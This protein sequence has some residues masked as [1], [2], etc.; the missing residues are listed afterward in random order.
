MSLRS[1]LLLPQYFTLTRKL[2]LKLIM[3]TNIIIIDISKRKLYHSVSNVNAL[4]TITTFLHMN[5]Q[6]YFS[7]NENRT[8]A[9]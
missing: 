6:F 8:P 9:T 1:R 2:F 5:L 7:Q 4:R 3:K